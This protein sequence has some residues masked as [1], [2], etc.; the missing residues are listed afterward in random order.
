MNR[1]DFLLLAAGLTGGC[2]SVNQ[3]GGGAGGQPRVV[4]AGPANL[5]QHDGVYTSFMSSGFFVVRSEGRLFALSSYCT[6]RQCKLES[7]PDRTFYCQCHG[8]TFDAKGKVT[9]GPAVKDLPILATA[10]NSAGHLL[11]TVG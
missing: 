6:H 9:E 3:T 11:V 10:T 1:R 4:D 8:S 7:E 2:T 5:Y